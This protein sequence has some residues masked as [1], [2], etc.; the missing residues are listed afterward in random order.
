MTNLSKYH[1]GQFYFS[2]GV[3]SNSQKNKCV[4]GYQCT[5]TADSGFR[6]NDR[7]KFTAAQAAYK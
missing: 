5:V 3:C 4:R 2:L 6:Q 7:M 1:S